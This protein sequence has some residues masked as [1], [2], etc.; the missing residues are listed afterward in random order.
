MLPLRGAVSS[1]ISGISVHIIAG[2]TDKE[3]Q[4]EGDFLNKEARYER[5]AEYLGVLRRIWTSAEPFDH[6]GR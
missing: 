6:A 4:S 5:A 3:Q 1:V 2:V